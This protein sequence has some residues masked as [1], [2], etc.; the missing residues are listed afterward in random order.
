V[1]TVI[2]ARYLGPDEFGIFAYATSVAAL[3]GIAGHL[4]LHGLVVRDIVQLAE[5]RPATLGTATTLKAGGVLIGYVILLLYAGYYEGAGTPAFALIAICGAALLF[6]PVDVIDYWFNA[7]LKARYVAVAR[8]LARLVFLGGAVLLVAGRADLVFFGVPYLVQAAVAAGLLLLLYRRTAEV[9][10]T[11][12]RFERGRAHDLLAQGWM[13][14]LSSF[15]AVI[16][17]KIDQ[18]MLRWL[19]DPAEVGLYAVAA[20]LSEALYFMPAAIVASVFPKLI[21][22]KER[23]PERMNLRLQ[24]LFDGLA[25]LGLL[26]AVAITLAAPYLVALFFG[27]DYAGSSPILVIHTWAAVFIFM[28]AA[29]S[30]WILI[31]NVLRFS[32]LTQGLGALSN[33][34][35][36]YM[37]IPRLGGEGAAWATLVSYAIASF[38][39]V[40]L[41][42]RTRPVF[43]MM[44]RAL[45]APV[46]Y[47]LRWL[48]AR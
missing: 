9:R 26:V 23:D 32:L 38:L 25:L 33:V 4:G 10:L 2:V 40:F 47:P 12:W 24:Q 44:S 48:R 6:T 41:Y 18:V 37:L 31:E 17:L 15:L 36:N 39:A 11:D 43:W 30:R 3:F 8:G 14:F 1:T 13:L 16:Y 19:A 45:L 28:R 20:R 7:F 5:Q 22:L 29:L 21:E 34:V 42:P 46:R 27:E 35:M